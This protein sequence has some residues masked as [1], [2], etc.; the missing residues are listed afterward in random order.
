MKMSGVSGLGLVS[1]TYTHLPASLFKKKKIK[2]K[3]IWHVINC[4]WTFG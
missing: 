1:S 3:I 4:N 2:L